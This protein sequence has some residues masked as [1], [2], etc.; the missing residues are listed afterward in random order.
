MRGGNRRQPSKYCSHDSLNI[1]WYRGS[2]LI[3]YGG[4]AVSLY[5]KLIAIAYT[6]KEL[7]LQ[8]AYDTR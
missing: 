5:A 2:A 4:I 7:C 3:H 1:R 8:F 6:D